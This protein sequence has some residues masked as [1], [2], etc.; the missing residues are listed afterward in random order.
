[1]VK[2][3]LEKADIEKLIQ[4]KYPKSEIVSGLKDDLEIVIRM[5]EF[6]VQDP[7]DL[8]QTIPPQEV[9]LDN[10]T[11]DA[12]KSGL[13]LKNREKTIPGGSMGRSRGM[14]PTF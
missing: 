12:D 11:I 9:R 8:H 6:I 10:G 2:L 5:D 14:L 7:K 13:A 1:M 3:T 4:A